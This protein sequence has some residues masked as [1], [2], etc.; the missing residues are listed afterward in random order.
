MKEQ[1]TNQPTKHKETREQQQ[2][3]EGCFLD[4][5]LHH[6]HYRRL[7]EMVEIETSFLTRT[8]QP[9]NQT[10]T[11]TRTTHRRRVELLTSMLIS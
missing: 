1:P 5:R 10:Q 11:E 6:H 9:T 8:N 4:R 7:V 2:T 3:Q